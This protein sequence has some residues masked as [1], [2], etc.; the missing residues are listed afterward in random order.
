MSEFPFCK[1]GT[2]DKL[3]DI[4]DSLERLFGPN[5]YLLLQFFYRDREGRLSG[6]IEVQDNASRK[7]GDMIEGKAKEEGQRD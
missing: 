2:Y 3:P 4:T 1:I 5:Q 7:F 6:S